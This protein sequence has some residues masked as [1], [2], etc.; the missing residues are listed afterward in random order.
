MWDLQKTINNAKGITRREAQGKP[1]LTCTPK[2]RA[3]F[4]RRKEP[5]EQGFTKEEID[6]QTIAL[7]NAAYPDGDWPGRGASVTS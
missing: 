4:D 2:E 6:G 1:P 7:R 5:G 3:Y